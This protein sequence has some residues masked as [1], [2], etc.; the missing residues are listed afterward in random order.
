MQAKLYKKC[1]SKATLGFGEPCLYSM[2]GSQL[3]AIDET[4][5]PTHCID[6]RGFLSFHRFP[7]EEG[8]PVR[9]PAPPIRRPPMTI[10]PLKD[11]FHGLVGFANLL[12]DREP[13][14][15]DRGFHSPFG[16]C[17]GFRQPH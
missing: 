16:N 2:A 3:R 17:Y 4:F 1:P 11:G 6:K 8:S 9:A 12:L 7:E 10:R 15:S 13:D 5:P 14:P